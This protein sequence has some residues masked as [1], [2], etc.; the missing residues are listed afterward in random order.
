MRYSGDADLITRIL[1]RN[2]FGNV[3]EQLLLYRQH[4]RQLTSHNNSRRK[5]DI[6]VMKSRLFQR[7][8][9]EAPVDLSQRY[10]D[11]KFSTRL[12]WRSRRAAKRE[13]LRL[14]DAIDA[15]NWV[16]SSE[17]PILMAEM[18]RYLEGRLP[19]RVQQFLH[20]RRHRFG[21]LWR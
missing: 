7:L 1:G 2:R 16:E 11:I 5:Q 18:N 10:D 15:E 4:S 17:K 6:L 21:R 9:A 14:I 12:S 13:I 3:A 19:R 20:W 8:F